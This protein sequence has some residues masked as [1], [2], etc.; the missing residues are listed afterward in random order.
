MASGAN[1]S[2]SRSP[3]LRVLARHSPAVPG[4]ATASRSSPLTAVTHT[5]NRSA[6]GSLSAPL[7]CSTRQVPAP[8]M[9]R[10]CPAPRPV[11]LLPAPHAAPHAPAPAPAAQNGSVGKPGFGLTPGE[12]SSFSSSSSHS[13][14][15]ARHPRR[16]SVPLPALA[17]LGGEKL[18][19][20]PSCCRREPGRGLP[21][22]TEIPR[23]GGT[24]L[25]PPQIP[26]S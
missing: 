12:L 3:K 4:I 10:L 19:A 14:R 5:P 2:P 24:V 17:G 22:G 9:A 25:R 23:R 7:T 18:R 20:A 16:G 8:Q 11:L 15:L 21:A 1:S 13:C 26:I 6:Q